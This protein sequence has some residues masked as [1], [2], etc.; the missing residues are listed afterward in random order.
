M[1]QL[2]LFDY[3]P[4]QNAVLSANALVPAETKGR[5]H[6]NSKNSYVYDVGEELLGAKKHLSQQS[7]VD[8][9]KIEENPSVAYQ[10]VCKNELL[11]DFD[12]RSLQVEGFTSE[13]AFAIKLIWA[14]VCQ[15]PEDTPQKRADYIQG[16]GALQSILSGAKDE[17]RMNKAFQ[18]LKEALYQARLST[19][20]H[21]IDEQPELVRSQFWLALGDRFQSLFFSTR[22]GR[23]GLYNLIQKAF[24][25]EQGKDWNWL[26]TSRVKKTTIKENKEKW[27]RLVPEE[28]VRKSNE[29]S[30]VNKP[31]DLIDIFGVRGVQFGNWVQDVAGRYHVLSCGHALNDLVGLLDIPNMAASFHGLLGLAFGARGS[32]SASA[33]YEP[34]SNIMNITKLRGGG[35]LCHEWAHA[36]D[37]NLY[38]FSHQFSNGKPL[39]LTGHKPGNYLPRNVGI[40]FTELMKIIKEGDGVKRVIVPDP[41]PSEEYQYRARV[42]ELLEM[43][44]YDI[45]AAMQV[46]KNG[47]FNVKPRMWN[48]IGLLYCNILQRKGLEV[49]DSFGVPTDESNF[50]L[51]ARSRGPY[52]KRDHELFARA[53]ESWIE[54]EL[55]TAQLDNS[56]LVT[57]TKFGGPYPLHE[58]REDINDAFRNWW[59]TLNDSGIFHDDQNWNR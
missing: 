5:V 14:R 12:L 51:D 21:K 56:Y 26:N 48:D 47:N 16:I 15:N 18:M 9:S 29:P 23:P 45:D 44:N 33:H 32:G 38:S 2:S 42:V 52:W 8:W 20:S 57:G 28:V 10:M 50:L 36:L 11:K 43:N 1:N 6:R 17:D 54:D 58:E 19:Y 53:F 22:R 37:F 35:S 24:Y 34:G 59:Q 31:D 25:S 49:P 46:L 13:A 7:R 41:L 27:E 4:N 40:A 3:F 30:G 55:H 39:S